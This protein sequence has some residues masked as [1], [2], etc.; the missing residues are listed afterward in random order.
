[1]K[2]IR[3]ILIFMVLLV[4]TMGSLFVIRT[5]T[6]SEAT[7]KKQVCKS[8]EEAIANDRAKRQKDTN[9]PVVRRVR[10]KNPNFIQKQYTLKGP[11][12]TRIFHNTDSL[13]SEEYFIHLT[14]TIL[15]FEKPIEVAQLDS[16]FKQ[17]LLKYDIQIETLVY[18]QDTITNKEYTSNPNTSLL[19]SKIHTDLIKMGLDKEI[20]LQAFISYPYTMIFKATGKRMLPYLIAFVLVPLLIYVM[21]KVKQKFILPP[22]INEYTEDEIIKEPDISTSSGIIPT[23]R[24]NFPNIKDPPLRVIEKIPI[25]NDVSENMINT[26]KKNFPASKAAYLPDYKISNSPVNEVTQPFN[27]RNNDIHL[28]EKGHIFHYLDQEIILTSQAFN[29]LKLFLDNAPEMIL[30]HEEIAIPVCGY[31]HKPSFNKA[32]QRFRKS[33]KGIP[34]IKVKTIKGQGYQLVIPKI[35]KLANPILKVFVEE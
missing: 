35:E 19:K 20:L 27:A 23:D 9:M 22:I 12:G 28:R 15:R 33:L 10:L 1:M 11:W 17:E 2:Y 7:I 18:Y 32:M 31:Y 4:P 3:Y 24:I 16:F 29:I 13:T 21:V 8:F 6:E 5:I 25:E 30:T 34:C 14:E 26:T